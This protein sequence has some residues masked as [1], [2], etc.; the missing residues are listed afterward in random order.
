MTAF[1]EFPTTTR[2]LGLPLLFVGQ[3]QKEFFVNQSLGVLD[4]LA[5]RVVEASL[6]TP[7]ADPS[8]GACF[9]ILAPATGEWTGHEDSIAV[10]IGGDWHFVTP[11]PGALI[12]D[13]SQKCCLYFDNVWHSSTLSANATGGANIDAEARALLAQVIDALGKLGLVARQPA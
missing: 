2:Q 7:P 4:A 1:G 10:R 8:D 9:R 12:H 11:S 3:S 5:H 6:T 13:L